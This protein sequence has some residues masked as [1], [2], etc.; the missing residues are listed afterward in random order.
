MDAGLGRRYPTR[1]PIDA[2]RDRVL[3]PVR[4]ERGQVVGLIGR[5]DGHRDNVPKY[6]NPTRTA[7]YDKSVNLYRPL[8]APASDGRV[9]VVEGTLDA[10]A[11]AIAA[12]RSGQTDRFC[13]VTQSGKGLS[14]VQLGQVI[15]MHPG[16]LVIAFDGD[17]AG[18][19]A[20]E[21]LF[22]AC[23]MRG[24]EATVIRFPA[25][26]DPSSWLELTGPTGMTVFGAPGLVP[27]ANG[28]DLGNGVGADPPYADGTRLSP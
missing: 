24:R 6:L 20:S 21:R 12:V 16:P 10:M 4:D 5:Y 7:T 23:R 26:H 17:I 13:P 2:Y 22:R 19:E 3:I 18:K 15:R 1:R 25:N 11:V 9:V 28:H 14:D 27:M 8:P